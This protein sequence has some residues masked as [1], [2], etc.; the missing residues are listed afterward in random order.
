MKN[1]TEYAITV[2]NATL[3]TPFFSPATKKKSSERLIIF[4]VILRNTGVFESP[5]PR[6]TA[7]IEV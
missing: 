5:N 2:A 4:E 3:A 1:A 7:A 6:K